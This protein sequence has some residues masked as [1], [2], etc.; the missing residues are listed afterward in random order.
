M[1]GAV[2]EQ[3]NYYYYQLMYDNPYD[4]NYLRRERRLRRGSVAKVLERQRDE[5]EVQ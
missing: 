4:W 2:L 3:I 5:V 1:G